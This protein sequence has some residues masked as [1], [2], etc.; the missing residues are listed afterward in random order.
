MFEAT[1]ARD[2]VVWSLHGLVGWGAWSD[3][4]RLLIPN[5]ICVAIV[6]LFAVYL[7]FSPQI[8]RAHV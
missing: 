4:R 2:V 1:I 8:G 3:Y 7:P 6:A 5:Q